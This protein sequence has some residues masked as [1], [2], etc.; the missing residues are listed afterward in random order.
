LRW[1]QFS[2]IRVPLPNLE[3]QKAIRRVIELSEREEKLL[4]QSLEK[5]RS[6]KRALMQ[7]LLTG[8]RRVRA[9]EP[10]TA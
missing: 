5:L 8:K 3:E 7:Q 2:N 6:E 9:T 4:K 10:A 1:K